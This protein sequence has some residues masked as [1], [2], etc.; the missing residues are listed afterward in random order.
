MGC[1]VGV[2]GQVV[3]EA[4]GAGVVKGPALRTGGRVGGGGA[5]VVQAT[6]TRSSL[7]TQSGRE[8]CG[9]LYCV[10]GG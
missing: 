9:V 8:L 7:G 10:G 1:W 6:L 2:R 5:V 4:G 3:G